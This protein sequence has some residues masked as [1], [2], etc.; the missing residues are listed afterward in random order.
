MPK[1]SRTP[2]IEIKSD[3]FDNIVFTCQSKDYIIYNVD[4]NLRQI[5]NYL[6]MFECDIIN[7]SI[8]NIENMRYSNL[9]V[10]YAVQKVV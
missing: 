3:N 8:L 9:K 7:D 10:E 2:S 1:H 5:L 4:E 6:E